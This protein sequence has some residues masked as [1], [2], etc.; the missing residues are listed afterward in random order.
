[1]ITHQSLLSIMA[2]VLFVLGT[3]TFITGVSVLVR[4]AVGGEVRSLTAQAGQLAQKGIAEDVAGLVGN[5]TTLLEAT[6]DLARTAAGVG[7]LLVFLGLLL[8]GAGCLLSLQF[9]QGLVL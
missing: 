7:I 5:V 8:M 6:N 4:R 2:L 3:G 9:G 1:M